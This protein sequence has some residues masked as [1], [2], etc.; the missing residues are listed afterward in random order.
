MHINASQR[1][2]HA[3]IL[4]HR[5]VYWDCIWNGLSRDAVGGTGRREVALGIA[6]QLNPMR[7][8]DPR[9]IRV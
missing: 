5:D 3:D 6:L 7:R 2:N 4:R 9:L 8:G 1:Q